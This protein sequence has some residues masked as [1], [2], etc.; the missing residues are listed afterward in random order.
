MQQKAVVYLI[1]FAHLDLFWAGSR[2]ECLSR[3]AEVILTALRVLERYPD[4]RFMIESVNFLEYFREAYPE[5]FPRLAEV[6]KTGRLEVIPVRA[7]L[8]NQLPSGETLVRNCLVGREWCERNFGFSGPTLSLSDIPGVTPQL[9]QIAK[10]SGFSGLLLS[11]GT[12]P[13]TDRV[14]YAALDGT[15]I[16]TYAP[17]HYGRC[18]RLFAEAEQYELMCRNEPQIEQELGGM[19]YPQLCQFGTDLCVIPERVVENFH[20]WNAEGHRPFLF[21][22]PEEYF[23][24]DFPEKARR[25]SGEIP[26]LWPNVESSWPDLWPQDLPAENAMF[27]AEFLIALRERDDD[28]ACL[29]LKQAWNCLLD[30]MD[31]NQNGIGGEIADAEKKDLKQCA[32]LMA[33]RLARD[34]AMLLVARVPA[35]RPNCFPLVIFNRLSWKREEL[36]RARTALYGPGT[37]RHPLLN[38]NNFRLIDDKGDMVPFRLVKHLRR[39][40]DSIEVE[41]SAEVPAFGCRA[42]FLEIAEP[43][44]MSSPFRIDDGAVRDLRNPNTAA[45]ETTVEGPF[46]RLS[47]DRITGHLSLFDKREERFLFVHAGLIGREEIRGDYICNMTCTSRTIPAVVE[48]LEIQENSPTA[49]RILLRGSIYGMQYEQRL[50]LPAAT[51]ELEIENT[52]HWKCGSYVRLEQTFPFPD[53]GEQKI[54]YGVPFG[55]VRYPENIYKD[56]LSFREIVTPERGSDPDSEIEH[57]RLAAQWV[58][59]GSGDRI[60][61]IGCDHRLWEFDAQEI[62]SC[63]IRGIGYCSGSEEILADGTRKAIQR[64]PDGIYRCRYRIQAGMRPECGWELN[65]PLYPVGVGRCILK[66]KRKMRLPLLPDTTGCGIFCS[67]VKPSERIPNA[68]TVRL[69]E[70]LGE[71]KELSLPEGEWMESDLMERNAHAVSKSLTFSPF[72]IKT[73]ILKRMPSF[74]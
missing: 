4:Y 10:K 71:R 73:L 50:T 63:M 14:W 41:F 19:A 59:F 20:R 70:M 30:S 74:H 27:L 53:A 35:P 68:I 2:E 6:V 51:A 65:A 40:A 52:I 34:S 12:P 25:I 17:I 58:A 57:L 5:E 9:P 55:K 56:G 28:G 49:C 23:K 26:S 48:S 62:R 43:E 67:C 21:S 64:P 37:A 61:T 66:E 47:I 29:L 72:E 8:Y 38:E 24:R 45:G 3:G 1:A 33:E 69:F 7:I 16:A 18:R 31:H 13:H 54:E 46:L 32:R 60:T 42:W 44:R 39:V 15:E 11:H 36:V 22:T